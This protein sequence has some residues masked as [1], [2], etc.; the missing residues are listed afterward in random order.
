MVLQQQ[1]VLF[2]EHQSSIGQ[3]FHHSMGRADNHLIATRH[4]CEVKG[5][6]TMIVRGCRTRPLQMMAIQITHK[7]EEARTSSGNSRKSKMLANS[8]KSSHLGQACGKN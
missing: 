1:S 7:L 8:R 2:Q 5:C 4:T 6:N 3:V